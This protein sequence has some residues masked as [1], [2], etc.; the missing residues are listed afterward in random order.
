MTAFDWPG[1]TSVVAVPSSSTV[2]SILRSTTKL[3]DALCWVWLTPP[4]WKSTVAVLVIELP[5]VVPAARAGVAAIQVI[6]AR[7]MEPA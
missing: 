2:R 1:T 5:A 3:S 4:T 7:P 6:A